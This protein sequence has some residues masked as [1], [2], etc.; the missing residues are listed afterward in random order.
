MDLLVICWLVFVATTGGATFILIAASVF[1][2][3]CLGA[4][5][6]VEW[7]YFTVGLVI[8]VELWY[9]VCVLKPFTVNIK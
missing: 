1:Q 3:V 9:L 8:V 4:L 5:K 2:S 7:I 6:G